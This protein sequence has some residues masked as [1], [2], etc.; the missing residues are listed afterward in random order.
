MAYADGVVDYLIMIMVF[1]SMIVVI[2]AI[3]RVV[4]LMSSV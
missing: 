4:F 2:S 1:L 3:W